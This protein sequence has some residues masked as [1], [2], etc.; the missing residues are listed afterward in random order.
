[1]LSTKTPSEENLCERINKR[2]KERRDEIEKRKEE[3]EQLVVETE[4][5]S[6]FKQA[7]RTNC[8][9]IRDLLDRAQNSQVELLPDLFMKANK[10]LSTLKNYLFESKIFLKV[11]DVRM[12]Q[13]TLQSLENDVNQLQDKLVPR[14]KFGFNNRNVIKKSP[15][16]SSEVK[17]S[18]NTP[19]S[20]PKKK[21]DAR[22][23]IDYGENTTIIVGKKDEN[24]KLEAEE[25]NRNDVLLSDLKCCTVRIFGT[26]STLHLVNLTH[27]TILAGPVTTSVFADDCNG[28]E[29]A[30]ACQQLRVHN[31]VNCQI[32]LHVTSR[33]IIEDSAKILVAPYNW[34]Y[35]NLADHFKLAG[36]DSEVN[37]WNSVDDFNWLKDTQSPNWSI[38]EPELRVKSWD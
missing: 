9:N 20:C 28:C 27:C 11:Y 36:L 5:A 31:S 26:P 13:Q 2:D 34:T 15:E 30:L 18:K 10:D 6:Y 23:P 22:R 1:M 37:N 21:P 16:E 35:E 32:Y 19:K 29:L 14:K 12:A 24:L 7:F 8:E 38:L 4:K 25:V 3:K 33:A 17:S